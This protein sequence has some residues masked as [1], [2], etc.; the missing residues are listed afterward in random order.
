M[1]LDIVS[2]VVFAFVVSF[3]VTSLLAISREARSS[4]KLALTI[5]AIVILGFGFLYL[6]GAG[7]QSPPGYP[8]WTI[9]VIFGS[10]FAVSHIAW[11]FAFPV[12]EDDA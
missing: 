1:I 6:L 9:P 10:M 12:V 2:T 4:H 3:V 8:H 5:Q 7:L 11:R